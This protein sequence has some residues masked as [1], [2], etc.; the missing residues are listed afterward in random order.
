MNQTGLPD[1]PAAN[2]QANYTW[3]KN[4]IL[5][6]YA[7]TT[8]AR[9]HFCLVSRGILRILSD[10]GDQSIIF[11]FDIF[12]SGFFW[13]R[14]NWKVFLWWLDLSRDFLRYSKQSEDSWWC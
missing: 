10:G 13:G 11:G 12:N 2:M 5:G 3:P 1:M 14:K 6:W 9:Y 7:S 4:P 8:P